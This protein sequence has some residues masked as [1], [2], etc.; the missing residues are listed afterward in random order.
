MG[1]AIEDVA[2]AIGVMAN[3]GIKSTMAGTALRTLLTK[4]S[5]EVKITG[6]AIG[7][8]TIKTSN[9]D[10]SMCIMKLKLLKK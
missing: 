5:D 8:V 10:G 4:L 9:A 1:F 3:S 7:E 2:E 6:D